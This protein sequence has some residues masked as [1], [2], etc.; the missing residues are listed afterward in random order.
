MQKNQIIETNFRILGN[1]NAVLSCEDT[2]VVRI[3]W[4][5]SRRAKTPK[6]LLCDN[7]LKILRCFCGEKLFLESL[8]K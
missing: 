7:C 2:R 3:A 1:K 6:T 5:S 4:G 8:I